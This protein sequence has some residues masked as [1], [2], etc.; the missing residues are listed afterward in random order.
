M[1]CVKFKYI[2][3]MTTEISRVQ[4]AVLSPL[5]TNWKEKNVIFP[6]KINAMTVKSIYNKGIIQHLKFS[7]TLWFSL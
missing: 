5:I 1:M 2:E 7:R 3:S 6:L 4:T